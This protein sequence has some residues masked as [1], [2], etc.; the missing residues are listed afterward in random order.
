[1]RR[2]AQRLDVVPMALYKHVANKD[3]LLDGMADT[4]IAGFAC[5]PPETEGA[6]VSDDAAAPTWRERMRARVLAARDAHDAHPWLRRLIETRGPQTPAAFR[7]MDR[8]SGIMIDAGMTPDLTHHAMHALGHRIWG[9]S[10][11]AR[12][13]PEGPARPKPPD[14][15]PQE[16]FPTRFPHITAIAMD[17]AARNPG[18]GCDEA[19]EFSFTLDLLLDAFDRLHEAGWVSRP[20]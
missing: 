18:R 5:G 8:L 3:D 20:L 13:T 6:A 17:A 1:M 15:I 16:D 11:D 7:H 12:Q 2:L 19:F 10:P 14:T 4:V 9:F